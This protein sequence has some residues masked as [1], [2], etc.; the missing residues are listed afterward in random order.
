VHGERR[1]FHALL[2]TATSARDTSGRRV[3]GARCVT[4]REV[5][6]HLMTSLTGYTM[7]VLFS[8]VLSLLSTL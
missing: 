5:R 8:F 6:C 1:M 7:D 3:N 4:Y 2:V